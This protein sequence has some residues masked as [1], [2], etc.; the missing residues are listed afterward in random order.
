[1]TLIQTLAKFH[2]KYWFLTPDII[3]E[4]QGWYEVSA[5][6]LQDLWVSLG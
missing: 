4:V 6:E 5:E 2:A 1:M 3:R